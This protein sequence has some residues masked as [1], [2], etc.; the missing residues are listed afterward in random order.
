MMAMYILFQGDAGLVGAPG[1]PGLTGSKV[2]K[3]IKVAT[4]SHILCI[5]TLHIL[6]ASWP[7]ST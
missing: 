1:T 6:F 7:V 5:F 2:K 4:N 3:K